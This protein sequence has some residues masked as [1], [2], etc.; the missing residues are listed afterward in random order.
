MQ[1]IFIFNT[2]NHS[3]LHTPPKQDLHVT[4]YNALCLSYELEQL[5]W[6]KMCVH[7]RCTINT[8]ILEKSVYENLMI[9][10]KK[11]YVNT[12]NTLFKGPGLQKI[13][14]VFLK[15]IW[16][17]LNKTVYQILLLN[18]HKINFKIKKETHNT[19]Y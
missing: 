1:Q 11:L 7:F 18:I 16:L 10:Y 19:V 6:N 4:F 3:N 8:C 5:P 12:Y 9:I 13:P 14:F 2:C 15:F 17:S